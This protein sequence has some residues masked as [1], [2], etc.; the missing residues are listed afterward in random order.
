M[1]IDFFMTLLISLG[2]TLAFELAFCLLFKVRGLY[3]IILVILVNVFTNPP[4]VFTHNIL[5]RST[6]LPPVVIVLVL[7]TAVIVIE[8]FCYK[9]YA[10]SIKHPFWISIGANMFSYFAGLLTLNII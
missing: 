10:R 8:G 6:A 1:Q 4:V 3:D 5:Q 2:L 9:F 7:E